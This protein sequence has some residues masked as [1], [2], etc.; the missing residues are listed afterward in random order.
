MHASRAARPKARARHAKRG[1]KWQARRQPQDRP[2]PGASQSSDFGPASTCPRLFLASE[3]PRWQSAILK[4]PIFHIARAALSGLGA[5]QQ[6]G[7]AATLSQILALDQLG[8]KL[9]RKRALCARSCSSLRAL[10]IWGSL[11]RGG[12]SLLPALTVAAAHCPSGWAPCEALEQL[13]SASRRAANVT[14]PSG[15]LLWPSWLTVS[16]S[17]PLFAAGRPKRAP[18]WAAPQAPCTPADSLPTRRRLATAPGGHRCR[19]SSGT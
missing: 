6:A 11:S 19:S 4:R 8:P 14:E 17:A 13:C 1:S 15:P 5:P 10:C 7:R 12:R 3:A 18:R 16:I 2:R 9:G